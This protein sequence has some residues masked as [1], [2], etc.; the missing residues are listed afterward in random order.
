MLT[1]AREAFGYLP[2]IAED[3]GDIGREVTDLRDEFGLPGMKVLQFAFCGGPENPFLPMHY[4]RNCV[5]YTGTHDNNTTQ[6]WLDAD[7]SDTELSQL[8]AYLGVQDPKGL[9]WGLIRLAMSSPAD[10]AIIPL[11]DVLGIGSG[12]RMNRPGTAEGNWAWRLLPGALT[13]DCIALLRSLTTIYGRLQ[14]P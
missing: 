9:V 14:R 13:Q 5:V 3:L 11:Q 7:A 12:G 6:G 8:R 10:R 4:V 1:A 2:I